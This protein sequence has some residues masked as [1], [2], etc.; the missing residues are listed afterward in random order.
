M[1]NKRLEKN[2]VISNAINVCSNTSV[3]KTWNVISNVQSF[4][5]EKTDVKKGGNRFE[6]SDLHS[7]QL[8]LQA[9]YKETQAW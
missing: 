5:L 1:E 9:R 3:Q 2:N 6:V 7:L 8:R 4:F